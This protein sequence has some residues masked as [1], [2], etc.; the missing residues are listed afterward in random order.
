[1]KYFRY[2]PVLFLLTGCLAYLDIVSDEVT[3]P[4]GIT[5]VIPQEGTTLYLNLKYAQD[6]STRTS[7][8][9]DSKVYRYRVFIN[10]REYSQGVV[11]RVEPLPDSPSI[12]I[13]A[14]DTHIPATIVVEGSKALDYSDFPTAWED[15]HE[16]YRGTQECLPDS[17]A[18]KYT[19][20]FNAKLGVTISNNT[21]TFEISDSGAGEVF[22]R[23][24]MGQT[25]S[26]PINISTSIWINRTKEDGKSFCN[27]MKELLP[28]NCNAEL[29]EWKPGGIYFVNGDFYIYLDSRKKHSYATY[30][31]SVSDF[32]LKAIK[33]LYPGDGHN[34]ASSVTLF[35]K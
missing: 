14:N 11:K 1:M 31:G 21:Y 2:L 8:A 15:W 3:A 4:D 22:K 9:Y 25:V 35:L 13:M 26:L 16:L 23:M 5:D 10:D 29:S 28:A 19:G 12:P 27:R 18:P 33:A 7:M 17:E 34:A 24:L 32:D 6:H 30:L 20:L